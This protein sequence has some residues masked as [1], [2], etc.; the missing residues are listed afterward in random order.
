MTGQ[1]ISWNL[2]ELF[3]SQDDPKISQAIIKATQLASQFEKTYRGKIVNLNTEGL[4]ECLKSIEFFKIKFSDLSLYSSLCFAANMTLPPNQSLYDR[5]SKLK[6]TLNKQLAFFGIE[7]GKLLESNPKIIT[8]PKLQNY[9]HMLE[10]VYRDVKHQLSEIEE[11]IIIEKDQFGVNAWQDL[12]RKWLN[13]RM[14]KVTV[15]REKKNLSYGEAN[16]L[17]THVDRATRESANK[18]IY[19][20]LGQDGE[21]FASALRS[22]CNDWVTVSKRRKYDSPMHASLI[23]NDTQQPIIDNLLRTI[24][25]NAKIYRSYLELKAKIMNLPQLGNHDLLAPLPDAPE[26]KFSFQQ[27]QELVTQA[28]SRLD[29]EY[30][31]AVKEMFSKQHIDAS[32]RFGKRNGAF[33]AC[34]YN[35]KSAYILSSFTGTL[36][37]VFTLAHELGHA[38]HDW[39]AS[40]NQTISNMSIPSIV[41]ETASIFGELL[42]TDQLLD[43]AKTKAEKTAVLCLVLDEAGMTAFQVSARVW[44]EQT[45]Y[46]SI[47]K[48][49]YLDYQT[50]CNLWTDARSRIYKNAVTWLPEM[51]AEWTM[52]P[53]YFMPNYRF[54]NYPYVYAQMFVYALYDQYLKEGKTFAPKLKEALSAGSSVSPLQ[55]G[56][57][58]NLD[59]SEPNFW[60]KGINVFERFFNQLQEII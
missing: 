19:G 31:T 30:A 34:Y 47:E 48:G 4:L 44:F 59:G 36:S 51:D 7:L 10:R 55:I 26:Q 39:Y 6:A 43:Q 38:T 42:L 3:S 40:R 9:K 27:A 23:S 11:Q 49:E 22:I 29:S 15:M 56:K 21:L 17:L 25:K 18:S 57:I 52:K 41:A 50:I 33:C 60:N 12:Q 46:S 45:L 58:V 24:E 20:T 32:P 28:Y 1:Q 53:H 54:Y 2:N 35:G 14:F 5:I 16:G 37:D 8:D 13:T